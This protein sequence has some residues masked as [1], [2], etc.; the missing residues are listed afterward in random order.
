MVKEKDIEEVLKL[1]PTDADY[2]YT[3]SE[4]SRSLNVDELFS[5]GNKLG[6]KGV[7]SKSVS[8]AIELAHK[9]ASKNDFILI[10]GSTFVVAEIDGL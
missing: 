8:E 6:L 3:Q 4:N 9:K 1:M 5:H 10:G 2:I 7:T